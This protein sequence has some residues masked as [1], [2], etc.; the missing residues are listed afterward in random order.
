MW[1]WSSASSESC[2]V[3]RWR[4]VGLL[5]DPRPA[6][7]CSRR[8]S[9][10]WVAQVVHGRR[11]PI[12]LVG[13]AACVSVTAQFN[14]MRPHLGW[15]IPWQRAARSKGPVRLCCNCKLLL[16]AMWP[17]KPQATV[18]GLTQHPCAA[19]CV[20]LVPMRVT[21]EIYRLLDLNFGLCWFVARKT[22]QRS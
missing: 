1:W 19:L 18:A 7:T 8:S 2:W 5:P 10:S 16:Q 15:R 11:L 20:F 6:Q 17:V 22:F 14:W 3:H 9:W 4:L 12:S 21:V 13:R